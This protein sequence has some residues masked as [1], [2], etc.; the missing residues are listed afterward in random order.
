MASALKLIAFLLLIA[1]LL[2][3]SVLFKLKKDNPYKILELQK[4]C[5]SIQI[6]DAWKRLALLYHPDKNK[7]DANTNE[8]MAKI[9]IAYDDLYPY[10]QRKEAVEEQKRKDAEVEKHTKDT[11]LESLKARLAELDTAYYANFYV[12]EQKRKDAEVEAR[13]QKAAEVEQ[14]RKDAEVE[15]RKRKDAEVEARKQKAAEVEAQKRKDAEAETQ[16]RKDAEVEEQ[17]RKAAEVEE[18]K[19][20]AAKEA[21]KQTEEQARLLLNRL[22]EDA[23]K[24][25]KEL[26]SLK[27]R[28]AELDAADKVKKKEEDAKKQEAADKM[29]KRQLEEQESKNKMQTNQWLVNMIDEYN[30]KEKI[31][32]ACRSG[33]HHGGQCGYRPGYGCTNPPNMVFHGGAGGIDGTESQ[34]QL[35]HRNTRW[36]TPLAF[37]DGERFGVNVFGDTKFWEADR[38]FDIASILETPYHD[39]GLNACRQAYSSIVYHVNVR[40]CTKS[41]AN[42]GFRV[43]YRDT[44]SHSGSP[45]DTWT[46]PNIGHNGV[47]Y[48][49]DY[50]FESEKCQYISHRGSSH[51]S[52]IWNLHTLSI[53]SDADVTVS[54]LDWSLSA[55]AR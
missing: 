40:V 4:P 48:D 12:E 26:E 23:K 13:K 50:H 9:N 33:N 44:T 25:D 10:Y 11:E 3:I 6:K 18:Q 51:G 35:T 27:A 37:F 54:I 52:Q 47:H 45:R 42:V 2:A 16:N 7:D 15:A 1:S 28:L 53:L 29:K 43:R 36:Y 20:K 17:K 46:S 32:A 30:A 39:G 34:I 31:D 41:S 38:G 8:K 21:K 14:K 24:K 22:T 55:L 49:G 5:S 19:R